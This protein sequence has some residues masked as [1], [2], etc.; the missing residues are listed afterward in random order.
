MGLPFPH[1]MMEL[2]EKLWEKCYKSF[3]R[4]LHIVWYLWRFVFNEF[5]KETVFISQAPG[6]RETLCRMN[7]RVWKE[8]FFSFAAVLKAQVRCGFVLWVRQ[9]LERHTALVIME[10]HLQLSKRGFLTNSIHLCG[11]R[12]GTPLKDTLSVLCHGPTPVCSELQATVLNWYATLLPN[13]WLCRWRLLTIKTA[14][15][16]GPLQKP[17][18]SL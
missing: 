11:Y 17:V 18:V 9:W 3:Y 8:Y 6:S 4:G 10:L 7:N 14:V 15:L 12:L 2:T 5:P 1:I 13:W 16:P